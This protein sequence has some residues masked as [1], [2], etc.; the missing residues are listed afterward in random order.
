MGK[1]GKVRGVGFPPQRVRRQRPCFVVCHCSRAVR[2]ALNSQASGTLKKPIAKLRSPFAMLRDR[3]LLSAHVSEELWIQ[4]YYNLEVFGFVV[5]A[6]NSILGT[7]E[8][9]Q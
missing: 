6:S 7:G 2:S 1:V 8:M 5:V 3:E 9:G 4:N